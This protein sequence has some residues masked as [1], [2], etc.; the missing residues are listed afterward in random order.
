MGAHTYAGD[1]AAALDGK[2]FLDL[3]S[4]D[5]RCVI[6]AALHFSGIGLLTVEGK[7]CSPKF[8]KVIGVELSALRHELALKYRARSSIAAVRDMVHLVH[9]DILSRQTAQW[10]S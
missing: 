6:S 2:V 10:I 4:A 1:L 7:P 5:G 8:K 3:G 9:D